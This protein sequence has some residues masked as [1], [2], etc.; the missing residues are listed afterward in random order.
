MKRTLIVSLFALALSCAHSKSPPQP[1]AQAPT[2]GKPESEPAAQKSTEATPTVAPS[3]GTVAPPGTVAAVPKPRPVKIKI[4]VRSNPPKANVFW[5][6][7]PLGPTPVTLERPRDSGPVDLIVR[8]DGYF[9]LHT[10]AYT[11]RNDGVW[12]KLTK[13]E[14]RMNLFGAK[15]DANETPAPTPPDGEQPTVPPPATPAAPA[16]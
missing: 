10:R 2:P 8:A 11:F 13:L 5:G 16:P 7:K 14:D 4:V 3:G 1:E 9:P 15:H 6:K 12:V